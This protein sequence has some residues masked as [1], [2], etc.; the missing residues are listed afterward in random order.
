M[1]LAIAVTMI[2]IIQ[3]QS[4]P[5]WNKAVEMDHFNVVYDDFLKIRSDLNDVAL[6]QFPKSSVVHMGAHYPVRLIF[7]NPPDTSGTLTSTNDTWINV[8]YTPFNQTPT[9]FNNSS[10]SI[11][12]VPNYNYYSNS[13]SL[14]YEHGLIIKD[15]AIDNYLYTD[16]N[17]AIFDNNIINIFILSYPQETVSFSG[18]NA[19][20]YNLQ[21]KI[22]TYN[23]TNVTVT[24]YTNYPRL[25]YALLRKYNLNPNVSG[26]I[27][28][29]DY[30]GNITINTYIF[31]GSI[32]YGTGVSANTTIPIPTPTPTPTPTE[33]NYVFDFLNITGIVTDFENA[34]SASD[35]GAL[36]AFNENGT[37]SIPDSNNYTYVSNNTIT[38]GSII[39]WINMQSNNS[40]Y[41]TLT[42]GANTVNTTYWWGFNTTIESWTHTW[43]GS[44]GDGNIGW[45]DDGNAAG[46]IFSKL[47][48]NSGSPKTRI[49]TWRSPQFTWNGDIP[50]SASLYFDWRV[51]TYTG[52]SPGNYYVQLVKPDAS[53]VQIYPTTPFSAT[54][55]WSS[56]SASLSVSDF[57][58]SGNYQLKLLATL[59]TQ[60][61]DGTQTV[62]IRWDN[63]TI[64]LGTTTYSLNITTDTVSV[65]GADI[66]YLEINYSKT[67]DDNYAVYVFNG[68]NW[69]NRGTL[70]SA[71]WTLFNYTLTGDEYNN[72][73]PKVRYVDE[74]PSGS[75]QGNL[76][77]DYQRV[78]GITTG[79]PSVYHM[80]ITTNTSDIPQTSNHILQIRYNTSGDNFTLQIWNGTSWNN[81]TALNDTSLSYRN[82]TLLPDELILYSNTEG[83][84]KYYTLVR[85][86][87]MDTNTT[88]QGTIYLD[89]QRIYNN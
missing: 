67:A 45:V 79:T 88:Q 63:P 60:G 40:A 76:Y 62:E 13:P 17:Q 16:T 21:S 89:Y 43:T 41:A 24:F 35:E 49:S 81:R 33:Y 11:K 51:R 6:F 86:L 15:F 36:A 87:D 85:Y 8:S 4:V 37:I 84:N 52:A 55:S 46:G 50:S 75:T 57:S 68:S 9:Y 34:R 1:L 30:P 22:S 83:I 58:Q 47:T 48:S 2:A 42:E 82:V 27:V 61:T 77:I 56:K 74:D 18:I 59:N 14:V 69:N 26:N 71:T 25:W 32:A 78:H 28:I 44:D 64:T 19:L 5:E 7:T 29:V 38:N 80:N 20:N 54:A 10:T 3:T 53:V 23:N 73:T 66:Q 72:G 65:P 12:F 31:N 39:N 70:N